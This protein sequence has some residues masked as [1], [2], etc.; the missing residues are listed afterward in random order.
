MSIEITGMSA[1]LSRLKNPNLS[2]GV[3]ITQES[4]S[5][6]YSPVWNR[7]GSSHHFR[8]I[9]A[10][11]SA[12]VIKHLSVSESTK[13]QHENLRSAAIPQG[14]HDWKPNQVQCRTWLKTAREENPR[15]AQKTPSQK[16]EL[17]L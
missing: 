8:M 16:A 12:P 10:L 17:F 13:I 7:S 4:L 5:S 3:F 11:P 14:A 6:A 9:K 2:L 1:L 15:R